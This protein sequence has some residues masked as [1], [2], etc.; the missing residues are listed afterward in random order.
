S[1]A[2]R[3]VSLA[4]GFYTPLSTLSR[5]NRNKPVTAHLAIIFLLVNALSYIGLYREVKCSLLTISI[6]P[7]FSRLT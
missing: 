7:R 2:F 1:L 5:L 3:T 6:P 4:R